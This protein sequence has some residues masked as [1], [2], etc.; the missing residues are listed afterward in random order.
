VWQL[1]G[2]LPN[3]SWRTIST[4]CFGGRP[5]QVQPPQVTAGDVLSALRRV[6]L[7]ELETHIQPRDKT[8]V[9][10]DTIFYTDPQPVDVQLTILG[11]AVDV[12][13]TPASYHWVF[14]DG[15]EATT[16]TPGDPYPAK[17][18]THRYSD[19]QV[20]VSAHVE[21]T[22]SARF[23]VN[24]GEWEEIPETV[25]TVGPP[26]VLRIAEADPLL[27]GQRP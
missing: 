3:G 19:A 18:V 10:F 20:T 13:A 9:N 27:S 24:G 5:P 6:G 15:S 12:A 4:Q 23:S 26:S 2:Q 14:G 16:A 7:P 21:V 25:T 11:Q 22:Y 1:W 8:L 17:T